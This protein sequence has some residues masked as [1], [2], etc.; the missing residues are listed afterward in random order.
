M[1][2]TATLI[3]ALAMTSAGSVASAQTCLSVLGCAAKSDGTSTSTSPGLVPGDAPAA[4][5][6]G[7]ATGLFATSGPLLYDS[8]G[9]LRANAET[10]QPD[11]NP[12]AP[13]AFDLTPKAPQFTPEGPP[14]ANDPRAPS[15]QAI[16]QGPE[17][18]GTPRS[19]G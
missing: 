16:P 7:S 5:L 6:G 3:L 13:S 17:I 14:P 15:L 11:Q 12:V 4:T 10:A 2:R 8:F 19:P 1:I 9:N 18:G